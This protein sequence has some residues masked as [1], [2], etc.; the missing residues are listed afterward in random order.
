MNRSPCNPLDYF[1][2][3]LRE[4]HQQ[5]PP[6]QFGPSEGL[7]GGPIRGHTQE[8]YYALLVPLLLKNPALHRR[9][10]WLLQKE[11]LNLLNIIFM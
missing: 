6:K 8:G 11:F 5:D 4:N 3:S 1:F 10:G 2:K 9:G 7:N